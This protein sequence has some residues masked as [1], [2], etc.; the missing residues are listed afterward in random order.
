MMSQVQEA[1]LKKITVKAALKASAD[2]ARRLA[3]A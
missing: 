3:K 2:E 1:L